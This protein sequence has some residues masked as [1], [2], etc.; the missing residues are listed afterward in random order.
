MKRFVSILLI[1]MFVL[2]LSISVS[3]QS[4]PGVDNRQHRQ[5]KRIKQGVKNG[6]LTKREAAKLEAGQAKTRKM[7]R[8]AK[9]DGIV[10][11]SERAKL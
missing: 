10:T 7:E 9:A 5:Q 6:S 2:A 3:A 1:A 4:T 11:A 8:K